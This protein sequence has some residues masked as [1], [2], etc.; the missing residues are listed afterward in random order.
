M[1]LRE[2]L[3]EFRRRLVISAGAVVGVAILG[4]TQYQFIFDTLSR[5]FS[6]YKRLHPHSLISL[7]FANATAAFSN[8]VNVSIFVGVLVSSPVWLYQVWA[9]IVPGLTRREKRISLAFVGAIAPL[10]LGGCWFGY[11]ILPKSLEILYG[12]TPQ[13]ASN[14]QQ[15]TDYFTFVMRF[16][17]VFGLAALFPVLLIG[18]NL[19]HVLPSHL[20]LRGWRVAVVLIFVFAA[21]ATPTPDAYT[22]FLLA[23]PLLLLYFAAYLVARLIDRRRAKSRPDW[24]ETADDEASAI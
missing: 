1:T 16:I 11:W 24:L 9:F 5:P 19:A 22:M 20:M 2:H 13:G 6:D 18:L 10:F 4:F 8:Q 17:L 12:F 15:T 21:V 7:N 14:I 3:L 23:G